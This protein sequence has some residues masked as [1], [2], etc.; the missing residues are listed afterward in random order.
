MGGMPKNK[1]SPLRQRLNKNFSATKSEKGV[2]TIKLD[3]EY[4]FD[5]NQFIKEHTFQQ[6]DEEQ[7]I[8]L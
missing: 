7:D 5:A 2:K 4:D 1:N 3:R 6:S 8:N